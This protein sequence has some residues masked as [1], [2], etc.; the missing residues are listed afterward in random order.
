[1]RQQRGVPH[2]IV[3]DE[4]HYLL[5]QTGHHA[6]CAGSLDACTLVTYRLADLHPDVCAA[7]PVIVSTRLTDRSEVQ[8]LVAL[9]GG[10]ARRQRWAEALADLPV[11]EA[12]LL[13]GSAE[14]GSPPIRCHLAPR[15]TAHVRHRQKYVDMPVSEAQAFVFTRNGVASGI[16]AGS[17]GEL[18]GLIRELPPALVTGHLQRGDFSRWIQ[19]VFGDHVLAARVRAVESRTAAEHVSAAGHRVARLI[20]ARYLPPDD[21]P[22]IARRRRAGGTHPAEV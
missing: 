17:L 13:Q 22:R 15:L 14:E 10:I 2:R 18:A 21:V 5:Q 11:G 3:L 20:E 16:R 9:G 1:M 6:L 19:D 7:V 8:A 12:V 4:A